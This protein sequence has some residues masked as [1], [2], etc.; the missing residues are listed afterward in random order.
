MRIKG[1]QQSVWSRMEWN[2]SYKNEFVQFRMSSAIHCER[3]GEEK[4]REKSASEGENRMREQWMWNIIFDGDNINIPKQSYDFLGDEKDNAHSSSKYQETK[5]STKCSCSHF[6]LLCLQAIEC[7]R[8]IFWLDSLRLLYCVALIACGYD[9]FHCWY[10]PVTKQTRKKREISIFTQRTRTLS[11]SVLLHPDYQELSRFSMSLLPFHFSGSQYFHLFFFLSFGSH[12]LAF[13]VPCLYL[14]IQTERIKWRYRFSYFFDF[15]SE[16]ALNII[17]HFIRNMGAHFFFL[18]A[19]MTMALAMTKLNRKSHCTWCF[20]QWP[21]SHA[22]T[23]RNL[24]A[25]QL[26]NYTSSVTSIYF[27][28]FINF[29]VHIERFFLF[30]LLSNVEYVLIWYGVGKGIAEKKKNSFIQEETNENK[31]INRRKSYW[32]MWIEKFYCIF[33]STIKMQKEKGMRNTNL[34][35]DSL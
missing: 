15:M 26:H 12:I 10:G 24:P 8:L 34:N 7:V 31:P 27:F 13:A 25:G 30:V 22:W 2:E 19:P 4:T 11:F 23:L 32:L 14:S 21:H 20:Q 6:Y 35:A 5:H 3:E 16:S 33:Y 1:D 18:Y 17:T 9:L 29:I 28:S